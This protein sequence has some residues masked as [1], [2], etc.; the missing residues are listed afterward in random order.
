MNCTFHYIDG[1]LSLNFKLVDFLDQIYPIEVEIKHTTDTARSASYLDL[2]LQSDSE[3]RNFPIK[4]M[5]SIFPLWTFHL[6][7]ATFQQHLYM[8]CISF[9]WFD[10]L[11][12]CGSYQNFLDR[13]LLLTRELLNQWFLLVKLKSSIRKSYGRHHDLVDRYGYVSFVVNTSRSFPH[14]WL[15]T[16]FVTK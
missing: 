8:E 1:V 4:E 9:S 11:E 5:I 16:G 14:A 2:H 6:Y 12:L 3:F 10:I 13:G 7:V 15:I